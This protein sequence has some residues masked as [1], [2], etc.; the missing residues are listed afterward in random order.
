MCELLV[1]ID[2]LL[3]SAESLI[4]TVRLSLEWSRLLHLADYES[5]DYLE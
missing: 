2:A 3:N 1:I 4:N 5:Q